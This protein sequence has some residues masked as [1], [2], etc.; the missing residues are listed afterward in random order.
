MNINLNTSNYIMNIIGLTEIV[1]VK[2][3][4]AAAIK[5]WA[6]SWYTVQSGGNITLRH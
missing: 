2:S 3:T 1:V 6:T 5:N 4:R